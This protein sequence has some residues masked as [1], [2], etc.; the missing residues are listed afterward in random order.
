MDNNY[1]LVGKPWIHKFTENVMNASLEKK[2]ILETENYSYHFDRAIYIN[3]ESKKIFSF[4]YIEDNSSAVLKQ[5]I[6]EENENDDWKFY[7]NSPVS[8]SVKNEIK[9]I[10]AR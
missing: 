3:R 2:K 7:F 1:P 9:G 8:E 4:E 6:L 5:D 10:L